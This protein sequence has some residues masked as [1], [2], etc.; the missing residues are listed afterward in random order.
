MDAYRFSVIGAVLL[1]NSG[2]FTGVWKYRSIV[3][4]GKSHF[5]IDT[6]HRA[7]FIYA[8]A[9]LL[10]SEMVKLSQLP[11]SVELICTLVLMSYFVTS[12]LSY[13]V[14]GIKQHTTNQFAPLRRSVDLFMWSLMIGECLSFLVLSYGVVDALI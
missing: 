11:D 3:R 2:L 6:A 12:V 10:L 9:C 1:F 5:Y 4:K 7:S 8:F 14:L 13:I